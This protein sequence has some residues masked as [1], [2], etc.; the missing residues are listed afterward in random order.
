MK[1]FLD[2]MREAPEGWVRAYWPNEV[3]C[4]LK[5]GNVEEISLDHDLGDDDKGNGYDV[6]L[7]IERAVFLNGFIAPV[8]NIHSANISARHKM[9]M[10]KENIAR[11]SINAS[12]LSHKCKEK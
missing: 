6:L 10:A 5:K 8:I 2:D 12:S 4:L 11:Y 9:E 3:I 7:W 1:I